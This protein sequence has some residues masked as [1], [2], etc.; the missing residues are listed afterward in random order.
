MTIAA[1]RDVLVLHALGRVEDQSRALHIAVGQ[2]RRGRTPLKLA[3][4]LLAKLD[5]VAAGPG[6]DS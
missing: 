4:I 6:H 3:T 2:R 1:R 5:P